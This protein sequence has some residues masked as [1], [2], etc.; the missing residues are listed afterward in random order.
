MKNRLV[1]ALF[2]STCLLAGGGAMRTR[3]AAAGEV[4]ASLPTISAAW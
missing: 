2:A 3:P 4:Q 1:I